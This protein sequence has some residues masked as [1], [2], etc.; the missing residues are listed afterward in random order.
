MNTTVDAACT[1]FL[2][3]VDLAPTRGTCRGHNQSDNC[4]AHRVGATPCLWLAVAVD[5]ST[6]ECRRSTARCHHRANSSEQARS[7]FNFTHVEPLKRPAS[8][9]ASDGSPRKPLNRVRFAVDSERTG[10]RHQHYGGRFQTGLAAFDIEKF[11]G[12]EIRTKTGFSDHIVGQLERG[13]G[14]HD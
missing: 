9:F 4:T 11:L 7:D 10:G 5:S 6:F 2:S 3:L 14:S 1:D 12:A 8:P 13:S